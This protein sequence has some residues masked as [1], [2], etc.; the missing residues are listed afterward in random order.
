MGYELHIVRQVNYEYYEEESNILILSQR[1]FHRRLSKF[2][3]CS[4]KT[5]M[6]KARRNLNSTL[7]F[8]V[9]HR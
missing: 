9:M 8:F 3:F 5:P 6:M 2:Q 7:Q 1:S 4:R